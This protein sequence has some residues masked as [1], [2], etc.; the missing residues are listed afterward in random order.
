MREVNRLKELKQ[1][2]REEKMTGTGWFLYKNVSG[3][4]LFLN[5]PLDSGLNVIAEGSTF[6]GD[7]YYNQLRP[8]VKILKDLSNLKNINEKQLL[9]EVPIENVEVINE[10]EN[11]DEDEKIKEKSVK[12]KR[13]RPKKKIS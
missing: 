3:G 7:S 1:K 2:I 9:I 12:K 13:G 10:D 11:E 5:K 4:D 8:D 6:E